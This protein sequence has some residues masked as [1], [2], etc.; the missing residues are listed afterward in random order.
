MGR[1]NFD[2]KRTRNSKGRQETTCRDDQ[3][4]Q[5]H[6]FSVVPVIYPSKRKKPTGIVWLVILDRRKWSARSMQSTKT[7][8]PE[9]APKTEYNYIQSSI[10]VVCDWITYVRV[11]YDRW[12]DKKCWV[13]SS[14]GLKTGWSILQKTLHR[15][16]WA[17]HPRASQ[18]FPEVLET[19]PYSSWFILRAL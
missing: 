9:I 17:D 1:Q 13:W 16:V 18:C 7:F 5:L 19:A 6:F 8:F 15:M 12:I 11:C 10:Q 4:R 14:L 2:I 3:T